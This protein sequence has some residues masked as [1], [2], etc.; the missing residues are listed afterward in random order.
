M[1]FLDEQEE[2]AADPYRGCR[3]GAC[4]ACGLGGGNLH[5]NVWQSS[6]PNPLPAFPN[7]NE[8]YTP[9]LLPGIYLPLALLTSK[10]DDDLSIACK[11][12]NA[13]LAL[14][15]A[16]IIAHE[17]NHRELLVGVV[18]MLMRLLASRCY[19]LLLH[20]GKNGFTPAFWSYLQL[21]N[22]IIE[23]IFTAIAPLHEVVANLKNL[24][25]LQTLKDDP[26]PD[27]IEAPLADIRTSLDSYNQKYDSFKQVF[28]KFYIIIS[29]LE[30]WFAPNIVHPDTTKVL[31]EYI[32]QGAINL[33]ELF[34]D[35]ITPPAL[36][37]KKDLPIF[38][39]D[40]SSYYFTLH[41]DP[42]VPIQVHFPTYKTYDIMERLE[43]ITSGIQKAKFRRR[44]NPP[45]TGIDQL[46]FIAK[47]IPGFHE[48]LQSM[49][50]LSWF[51]RRIFHSISD[52]EEFIR[53]LGV[54]LPLVEAWQADMSPYITIA[55]PSAEKLSYF[56]FGRNRELFKEYLRIT[57]EELSKHTS[58]SVIS[59]T[60]QAGHPV[61]MW[62]A[63]ACDEYDL[64]PLT[65]TVT[66]L[67]GSSGQA[68]YF[69]GR[70][71][72]LTI[73][74]SLRSQIAYGEGVTCPLR[75]QY[76]DR[77]CGHASL[78]WSIYEAGMEAKVKLNWES[79][80]IEPECDK[81]DNSR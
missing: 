36:I 5:T 17:V 76:R 48:W 55:I 54:D 16:A 31:A 28:D 80:W 4:F 30:E 34:S 42:L 13:E 81:P 7:P 58:S 68:R 59:Y 66:M 47:L 63:P 50:R 43:A 37:D 71:F 26:I 72:L 61:C 9:M 62:H 73:F 12:G 70:M 49:D 53:E 45:V 3:V 10:I 69:I 2:Q 27:N 56:H 18:P 32:I 44:K 15:V 75:H 67:G 51:K 46:L 64:L 8:F 78:V 24:V 39:N 14:R 22:Q 35:L 77:C 25:F 79:D 74:E 40:L 6:R 57:M 33:R 52:N 11:I 1:A 29:T 38:L 23:N 41:K 20:L 65:P 60:R 21:Q 19:Y